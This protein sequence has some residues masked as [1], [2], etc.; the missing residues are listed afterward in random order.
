MK[1]ILIIFFFVPLTLKASVVGISTH[2]MNESARV[3]SAEMA[4]YMSQKKEFGAG[5]RYTQETRPGQLFDITA[6]G[7]QEA[8]ALSLGA[9][10]DFQVLK[11]EKSQPRISFKPFYQYQKYQNA[12]SDLLGVA[13][14]I[15]KGFSVNGYEFFPFLAVPS[16]MKV[17][18]DTNRYVYY[19]ALS[20]GASMPFP[21]ADNDKF[22]LSLEGNKN[23][24]AAYDY[25]SALVSWV[26]K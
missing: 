8:R 9:G 19:A 3:I 2:P 11:E 7:A 12:R 16:G 15:R 1:T 20:F 23:L 4:G 13:P 17:E 22:L 26:W 21:G 25:V 6:A 5:L 24:G 18:S 10:Y 14:I